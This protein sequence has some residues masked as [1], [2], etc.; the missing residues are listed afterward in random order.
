[1]C[2][3]TALDIASKVSSLLIL[4]GG[5]G[6]GAYKYRVSRTYAPRLKITVAGE[7]LKA[8]GQ[9][10]LQIGIRVKNTGQSKVC[11][12]RDGSEVKV[13]T[14]KADE[15]PVSTIVPE[16]LYSLQ[17]LEKH[18]WLESNETGETLLLAKIPHEDVLGFYIDVTVSSEDEEKWS[19]SG[20]VNCILKP[21]S[22]NSS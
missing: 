21:D 12:S 17:I 15:R 3:L 1:M 6:V 18:K 9:A 10:Y 5:I 13:L 2:V 14:L 19:Q 22:P 7:M 8:D 11:I 16:E 20:I 4:L